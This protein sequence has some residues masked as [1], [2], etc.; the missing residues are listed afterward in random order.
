MSLQQ[1]KGEPP[2]REN[3][4][5]KIQVRTTVEDGEVDGQEILLHR[6]NVNRKSD[7]STLNKR[8]LRDEA[9]NVELGE[10]CPAELRG[11][12][13]SVYPTCGGYQLNL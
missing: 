6:R 12:I 11:Y 5:A 7:C 8:I 9:R 2:N 3:E 10:D 4:R 1:F 13:P